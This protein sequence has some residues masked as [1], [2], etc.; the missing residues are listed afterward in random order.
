MSIATLATANPL[1]GTWV[2][3]DEFGSTVEYTV[4]V[5]RSGLVVSATD[6]HDGEEAQISEV[7]SNGTEL[8]F[9][10]KWSSSGRV[11]R[12]VMRAASTTQVQF[13]FSYT[14][15]GHLQRKAT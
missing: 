9:V 1:V 10:A 12:C 11:C 14:E 6:S 15:H 8:C 2:S 3:P 13:T 4:S 7:T 5:G